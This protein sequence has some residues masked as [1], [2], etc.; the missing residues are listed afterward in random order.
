MNSRHVLLAGPCIFSRLQEEDSVV[1]SRSSCHVVLTPSCALCFESEETFDDG[2]KPV[3]VLD[4]SECAVMLDGTAPA[5]N[6]HTRDAVTLRFGDHSVGLRSA[7][8]AKGWCTALRGVQLANML[9]WSTRE[10]MTWV[11]QVADWGPVALEWLSA[12]Q[13]TGKT[14]AQVSA[15]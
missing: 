6:E 7:G 4:V 15:L 10:L 5:E 3:E 1:S 13:M 12:Q 14:L 2:Q 8:P 11:G 9:Q